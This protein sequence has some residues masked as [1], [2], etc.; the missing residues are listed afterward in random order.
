MTQ[1]QRDGHGLMRAAQLVLPNEDDQLLVVVDQ[2]EEL[3]TLT[4]DPAQACHF[5]DL[6][7]QAVSDPHSQVRVIIT[8]RADFYDRPLMEPDFS[9][10][11][12]KRT[13]VVV[14]L[15]TA[16]L[17]RAI[18]G[19]AERVGVSLEPG[20]EAE[21]MA[22]VADQ[23][24]SLPLLQYA[25]TELFER[26]QGR[27]LTRQAYQSIGSVLGALGRRAEEV[28]QGL[29]YSVQVLSRQVFLRLVSLGEGV[30]DTRRR[31]LRSEL[32]AIDIPAANP[33]PGE[34][35]ISVDQVLEAY[36]VARLLSF[37]H[38]PQTRAPT[39]EVAHEALLREWGHLRQWLNE[40][41]ADIR[42]Q[43]L[44]GAAAQDWLQA[45]QD[46]SFLLRGSRLV[47]FEGWAQ[48]TSLA[49]TGDEKRFLQASLEDEAQ[50][51]AHQEALERRSRNFLRALVGV[52]AV[53][54]M[55][56]LVLTFLALNARNQATRQ[57][58]IAESEASQRATQ[59][60]I[61]E[62]EVHQ[63]A[64][65]Q[66]IAESEADLRATAQAEAEIQ[67]DE[68]DRQAQIAFSRELVAA[69]GRNLETNPELSNWLALQAASVSRSAG[70]PISLE[71]ENMLHEA[72]QASRLRFT[73]LGHSAPV[74][75][76][77]YSPDGKLVASASEDHTIRLW[78]A[79]TGQE[80][81][82]LA[83]H[84]DSVEGVAFSP[85]GKLLASASADGTAILWDLS[86]GE[87]ELTL[88]PQSGPLWALAFS[89]DGKHLATNQDDKSVKV[90][91][92]SAGLATG[93][94]LLDLP[95]QGGLITFSPDATYLATTGLDGVAHVWNVR[96]GQEVLSIPIETYSLDFSPDGTH[97]AT[98]GKDDKV[99]I[100]D[101]SSGQELI[102]LCCHDFR[103]RELEFNPEGS[104]LAT[105][106]QE[107]VAKVWDAETGKELITLAGHAGAVDAVTFSPE[108]SGPPESP[109]YYCGRYLATGSRDGAIRIWD[110]SPAGRRELLT[111][112]GMSGSYY[113][114]SNQMSIFDLS[115]PN[116]G[117]VHRWE[118]TPGSE[119]RETE[120]YALPPLPAPIVA[121]SI[122]NQRLGAVASRD[123]NV[124]VWDMESGQDLITYTLPVSPGW[125][126]DLAFVP[127]G[128]RLVSMDKVGKITIW[129]VMAG[130][131][132]F[133][134]PLPLPEAVVK[135]NRDGTQIA[136]GGTDG[137][138]KIWDGLTGQEL[139]SL[140]GSIFPT[141][142]FSP[143]GKMLASG[144]LDSVIKVWDLE[145]RELLFNLLGH[146]ST[147]MALEFSPDGKLL[148][149][150]SLDGATKV[151]DVS[152]DSLTTG[153]E[154][155]H[156]SGP[157]KMVNFIF[158]S[159]DGK[160]LGTG[161]YWDQVVRVYTLDPGELIS[162]ANS[163]L[164]RPFTTQEC[165][166]YL[167]LSDC[168]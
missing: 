125:V 101:V 6:I 49:L 30:E 121:G 16:E 9:A 149:S 71:L 60:V 159:P 126:S 43:R 161:S 99:I 100:W 15:S 166:Q 152:S 108:C 164:T 4:V 50:R 151:W 53:A 158:F 150:G 163:R 21:I 136:T 33:D 38:D 51:Q 41:R 19:P 168:P 31:V 95:D 55:V 104:R 37:D 48:E 141:I 117:Q 133:S 137:I 29:H 36:G 74:W 162:I 22:D 130:Q 76:V 77:A 124:Q 24:G 84:L 96:T 118:S 120:L 154:L 57:Q 87:A 28:Y 26:R 128:L 42:L 111:S 2:F 143:D 78:D 144:G 1:L 86:S 54:T 56:A 40:S 132:L 44:L 62:S 83:G 69:A 105:A 146:T 20:L 112:T 134:L 98:G 113:P 160:R 165:Q 7:F 94:I 129:D 39:V 97:L 106:G 155:H 17:E 88:N 103:L 110:V 114:D 157:M 122:P 82:V 58:Q 138:I 131:P 153:R 73:L 107:G 81:R 23:P 3:F 148:A 25:L 102:T 142:T 135:F 90:W 11:V 45:N 127:A 139:F 85:D 116:Q 75:S 13:E 63:R 8:L 91:D 32:T 27:L 156:F 147:I 59:Q 10:L 72:V 80:L 119:P 109:F 46:P 89:P 5:M 47:Q 92:I 65:Q 14:P 140:T 145:T 12:Q 68:A 35:T 34:G 67:R 18:C 115:I 66:A 61:A 79:T 93:Q 52:F 167:H 123:G 70:I 64:T